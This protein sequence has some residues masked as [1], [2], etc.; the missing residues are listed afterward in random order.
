MAVVVALVLLATLA[1]LSLGEGAL[2]SLRPED[3]RR[4]HPQMALGE[5]D[6]FVFERR[7]IVWTVYILHQVVLGL[8]VLTLLLTWPWLVEGPLMGLAFIAVAGSVVAVAGDLIPRALAGRDPRG[9]TRWVLLVLISIDTLLRPFFSL[10][11]RLTGRLTQVLVSHYAP[12]PERLS[13]QELA[14]ALREL[15]R[16]GRLGPVEEE[17]VLRV[18]GLANRSAGEVMVPRVDVVAVGEDHDM[19]EVVG[20]IK[21]TGYSRIL[22][23]RGTVDDVIGF[24]HAK[25]LLRMM[26]EGREAGA[27]AG[28]VCRQAFHAPEMMKVTDLLREFQVRKIHVAVVTDE[29]GGTAG[30]VGIEDLLE[31][32]FGEIKDELDES[33]DMCTRINPTTW[34]IDGRMEAAQ[35]AQILGIELVGDFTTLGGFVFHTLGHLPRPGERLEHGGHG[36]EVLR[37]EQRR[38]TL[39]RIV[40]RSAPPGATGGGP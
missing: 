14:E 6:V 21:R 3:L 26:V 2:L 22:V 30:I 35:A 5:L 23:Y 37:M 34:V 10:L 13:T 32:V 31:E 8:L 7:R 16:E 9:L 40:R 4:L 29:Y 18:L 38:V 28:D 12:A 24:V 39:V 11:E 20:G 25:D 19:G 1:L 17:R 33:E 15:R 36:F 27:R